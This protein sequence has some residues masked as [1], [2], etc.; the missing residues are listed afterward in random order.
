MRIVYI[1]GLGRSGSTLLARLLGQ[2]DGV[3]SVG[4]LH[5]LWKTGAPR[6]SAEELCGCGASF[7]DCPFWTR[8]LDETLAPGPAPEEIERMRR[9]V[10]RIRFIPWM[11]GA[12]AP[13]GYRRRLA[14]YQAL[15]SR[16]YAAVE[17][18]GEGGLVVDATKDLSPLYLLSTLPGFEVAIVHLVRDPRGVAHSWGKRTR[19]PEFVGREVYMER[20][21][22]LDS[23]VRWLYSNLL[24]ES[25]RRRHA[26]YLRLR[27]E[28][29][30]A[31]PRQWME[32]VCALAGLPGPDLSFLASDRAE[33]ARDNHILSGNPSRFTSGSIA[34][35]L[36]E[37]WRREM[38]PGKRLLVS[39]LTLPLRVRYGYR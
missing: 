38:P 20:H 36:D 32:R 15:V 34:L 19:R 35:R 5:H 26:A 29:L 13:A 24:A 6:R 17:R 30:V 22:A 37:S 1:A 10:D 11:V 28:D 27:Y 33:V 14:A 18:A 31:A 23:S 4:E 8:V 12:V 2:L 39:A 9:S 16:L 7:R 21:G 25:A 3:V